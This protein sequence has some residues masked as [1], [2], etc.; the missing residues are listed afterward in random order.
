MHDRVVSY[1]RLLCL[2]C[3]PV[4]RVRLKIGNDLAL[5]I[6]LK[7]WV[8]H[9]FNEVEGD[10]VNL[11]RDLHTASLRISGQLHSDCTRRPLVQPLRCNGYAIGWIRIDYCVPRSTKTW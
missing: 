11:A 8:K 6:A 5:L 4:F 10:C 3:A 1:L 7:H 9:G 2:V